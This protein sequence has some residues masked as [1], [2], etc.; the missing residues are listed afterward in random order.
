M[1]CRPVSQ[2]IDGPVP[3][4]ARADVLDELEQRFAYAFAQTDFYR[5]IVEA[6]ELGD[7]LAFGDARARFVDQPHG[8]PTSLGMRFDEG[9]SFGRLCHRFQ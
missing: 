5:P 9:N 3:L 6:R 1:S 4:H 8:G 2:A 7:E